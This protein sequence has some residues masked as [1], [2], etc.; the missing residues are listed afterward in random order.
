MYISIH[1]LYFTEYSVNIGCPKVPT[2]P[3]EILFFTEYS[4]KCWLPEGTNSLIFLSFHVRLGK[5]CSK[6]SLCYFFL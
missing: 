6:T 1:I 3:V 5:T 2:F 4:V